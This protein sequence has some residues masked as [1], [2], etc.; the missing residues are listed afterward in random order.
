MIPSGGWYATVLLP[1][2]MDDEATAYR[3]LEDNNVYVHP[4]SFF[5]FHH[6]HALV[7]SLLTSPEVFAEGAKRL[8]ARI[9]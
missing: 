8:F 5:D 3:L 4:G 2:M 7:V 6:R 1:D 9:A